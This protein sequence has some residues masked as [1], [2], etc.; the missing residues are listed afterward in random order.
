MIMF[1][2]FDGYSLDLSWLCAGLSMVICRMMFA[3]LQDGH[4]AVLVL[5]N[6]TPYVVDFPWL[7][8]G[9]AMVM[10]CTFHD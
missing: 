4:G 7:S 5:M 2:I 9:L 1:W 6:A 10:C 8:T 3:G